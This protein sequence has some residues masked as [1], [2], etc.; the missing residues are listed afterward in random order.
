MVERRQG[1]FRHGGQQGLCEVMMFEL[2][3]GRM[4]GG[5][6]RGTVFWRRDCRALSWECISY[7]EE[8]TRRPL[9]LS[10]EVVA[11][12]AEGVQA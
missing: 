6:H 9:C 1:P 8:G 2:R 7:T 12:G 5:S 4:E 11:G 10:K 3:N